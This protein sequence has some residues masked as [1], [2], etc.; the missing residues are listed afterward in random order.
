LCTAP[1]F[2][3]NDTCTVQSID[4]DSATVSWP[5]PSAARFYYID[6]EY[7]EF[8]NSTS[9]V[10]RVTGLAPITDYTFSVRVYGNTAGNTVECH[11]KTGLY[12]QLTLPTVHS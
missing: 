4:A 8:V 2:R 9:N 10:Y 3:K 5:A 6:I 1:G 11:A 12:L 7:G